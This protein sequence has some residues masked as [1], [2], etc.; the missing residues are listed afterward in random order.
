[1]QKNNPTR[2]GLAGLRTN[3]VKHDLRSGKTVAA[4]FVTEF[5]NPAVAMILKKIGFD[6]F[7]LDA[8]H[9]A[10]DRPTVAEICRVARLCDISPNVRVPGKTYQMV[11]QPLDDGAQGIMVP[12]T[13]TAEEAAEIVRNVKYPPQGIRGCSTGT[14][15]GEHAAPPVAEF[16]RTCNKETLIV[17]QVESPKAVENIEALAATP[18]VDA[19]LVGPND[20]SIAL[21]LPGQFNHPRV[22]TI[23]ER[24]IKA[25]RAADIA[26]GLH[27]DLAVL[28][29]WKKEGIQL[30]SC[31]SD[32]GMIM[33]EGTRIVRD[34]TA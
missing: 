18:G 22:N 3:H 5:K 30:L 24:V 8:E 13:E 11:T 17:L 27:A 28:L 34:L 23:I 6:L 10:F 25:C 21:G 19:L 12:F 33:A 1:M 14:V 20:L 31:S 2:H 4:T 29:R 15:S 16:I 7:F 26:S 9:G 32:V